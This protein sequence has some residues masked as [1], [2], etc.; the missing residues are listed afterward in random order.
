MEWEWELR[1]NVLIS[2]HEE[3]MMEIERCPSL[4]VYRQTLWSGLPFYVSKS[5]SLQG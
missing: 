1:G 2:L 5:E 4:K 3:G